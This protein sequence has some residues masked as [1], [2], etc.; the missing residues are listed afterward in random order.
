MDDIV[1]EVPNY[2][3]ENTWGTQLAQLESGDQNY[4]IV[5]PGGPKVQLGIKKILNE[6]VMHSMFWEYQIHLV[7]S[8]FSKYYVGGFKIILI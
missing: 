4:T 7:F 1:T 2:N 3:Q 6:K 8:L 5:M